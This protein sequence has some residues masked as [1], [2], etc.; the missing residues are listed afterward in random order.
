MPNKL[1]N[2]KNVS[3]SIK[4]NL[5][6]DIEALHKEDIIPKLAAILVGDDPPSKIYISNKKT[7]FK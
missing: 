7:K 1:L 5:K 6:T 2:G 3:I 4:N